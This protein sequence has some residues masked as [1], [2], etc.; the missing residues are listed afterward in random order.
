MFS[1]RHKPTRD[2][3]ILNSCKTC[4]L[5]EYIHSCS[6]YE[7]LSFFLF[8]TVIINSL[9]LIVCQQFDSVY[10]DIILIIQVNIFENV[11]YLFVRISIL[12]MFFCKNVNLSVFTRSIFSVNIQCDKNSHFSVRT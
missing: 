10:D 3:V 6:L 1:F 2:D 5:A 9:I 11:H 7:C 8:R 4:F 12:R